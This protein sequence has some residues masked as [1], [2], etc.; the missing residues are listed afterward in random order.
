VLISTVPAARASKQTAAD[1]RHKADCRRACL[2]SPQHGNVRRHP[3]RE[4]THSLRYGSG[5][6]RTRLTCEPDEARTSQTGESVSSCSP[7]CCYN[8]RR[9]PRLTAATAA[10]HIAVG[11]GTVSALSWTT[12][13]PAWRTAR[14]SCRQ[15]SV[16]GPSPLAPHPHPPSLPSSPSLY[17]FP[18]ASASY[19]HLLQP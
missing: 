17:S 12:P 18:S 9:K 2:I 8:H 5:M 1:V 7:P 14:R 11:A 6:R 13:A 4:R 15:G 19:A 16:F 3:P 10:S